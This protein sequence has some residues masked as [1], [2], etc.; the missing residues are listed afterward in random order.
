MKKIF[1]KGCFMLL[2]IG[3]STVISCAEEDARL[4]ESILAG[5]GVTIIDE[6]FPVIAY[7]VSQKD[8]VS[9][10]T[11]ETE[12]HHLGAYADP[13]FGEQRVSFSTQLLPTSYNPDFGSNPVVDSVVLSIEPVVINSTDSV[14]VDVPQ[15]DFVYPGGDISAQVQI[16]SF[17]LY[18]YGHTKY[19]AG[20]QTL[21]VEEITEFM[22]T[23]KRFIS[24]NERFSRGTVLG[25]KTIDG[26]AREIRITRKADNSDL[27][28]S[29]PSIRIRLN[30]EYFQQK[31]FNAPSGVFGDIASFTRYFKGIH[32][33]T[34]ERD[35][36]LWKFSP[37]TMNLTVYYKSEISANGTSIRT[38]ST[39]I[40]NTSGGI[41]LNEIF[42]NRPASYQAILSS[43]K[44]AG[45]ERLYLQG[46]GG[47]FTEIKFRPQDIDAIR[48][49]SSQGGTAVLSAKVR[50][51]VDQDNWNRYLPRIFGY[52]LRRKGIEGF[53]PELQTIGFSTGFKQMNLE[54]I[55]KNPGFVEFDV[56][57]TLQQIVDGKTGNIPVQVRVGDLLINKEVSNRPLGYNITDE[58]RNINRI[59]YVGSAS[60][61]TAY[62][63]KLNIIY[64]QPK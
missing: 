11:R 42:Y 7:N 14:R 4:G 21:R 59:P 22:G 17:P 40:F 47:A 27:F 16:R 51:Y 53:M 64:S 24:S 8:S 15:K 10:S 36:Y 39:L 55:N 34:T 60:S 18:K 44:E 19:N 13:V 5:E 20:D 61:Q 50:L 56:T 25:Q 31:I 46:M 28:V 26:R 41:R 2:S 1:Q 54:S 37:E 45:H 57:T 9:L 3:L 49:K 52:N 6:S 35:G 29:K 12:D 33:S 23:D 30:K 58:A 43:A 38:P 32:L 48:M 62:V 63:P